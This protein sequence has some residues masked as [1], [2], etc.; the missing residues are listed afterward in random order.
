ME[1]EQGNGSGS[2]QTFEVTREMADT[3]I[4]RRE[5]LHPYA[6]FDPATTA[7]LVVDMQN[8]FMHESQQSACPIAQEVVPNVNRLADT[9]RKSGGI[10]VWIQNMTPWE[11]LESWS[12]ARERLTERITA[13]HCRLRRDICVD[14]EWHDRHGDPEMIERNS[15][16]ILHFGGASESGIEGFVLKVTYE[17]ECGLAVDGIAEGAFCETAPYFGAN[18]ERKRRR[19]VQEELVS[20]VVADDNPYIWLESSKSITDLAGQRSHALYGCHV[21]GI[22][23]AE[24]LRRM[25]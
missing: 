14:V 6:E 7:L 24:E 12:A 13:F 1:A 20:V 2:M 18:M 19:A 10:V 15:K 3:I 9:V 23:Q 17:A 4:R 21:L 22:G 5:H 16:R 11:S 8:Y 25:R